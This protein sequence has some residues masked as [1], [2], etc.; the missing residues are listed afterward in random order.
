MKDKN[1]TLLRTIIFFLQKNLGIAAKAG[2]LLPKQFFH[3]IQKL[4]FGGVVFDESEKVF[5][6]GQNKNTRFSIA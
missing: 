5:K 4:R 2:E 3:Y 6:S 1:I